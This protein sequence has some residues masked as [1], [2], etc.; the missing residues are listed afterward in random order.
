MGELTDVN[1]REMSVEKLSGA[2]FLLEEEGELKEE[3]EAALDEV[4]LLYLLK[5]RAGFDLMQR[6]N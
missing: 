6:A 5:K 1:Q 4:V 2:R 3:G